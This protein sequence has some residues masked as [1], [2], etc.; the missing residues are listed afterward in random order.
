MPSVARRSPASAS[1]VERVQAADRW[2]AP[3]GTGR[4]GARSRSRPA[5]GR[6]RAP[7]AGPRRRP[8]PARRSAARSGRVSS[9]CRPASRSASVSARFTRT[10]RVPPRLGGG[11]VEVAP[12][13]GRDQPPVAVADQVRGVVAVHARPVGSAE[14][15]VRP[16]GQRVRARVQRPHAGV[17]GVEEARPG[18]GGGQQ[19]V[20]AVADRVALPGGDEAQVAQARARRSRR[21]ARRRCPIRPGPRA[22]PAQKASSRVSTRSSRSTRPR[23]RQP[24]ASWV[25]TVRCAPVRVSASRSG[26]GGAADPSAGCGGWWSPRRRPPRD[27]CGRTTRRTTP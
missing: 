19:Q 9:T 24:S 25:S 23:A 3:G 21:S 8:R 17:R 22:G 20:V 13:R 26:A 14:E 27:R 12:G 7:G 16:V 11:Q 6:R 5:T 18:V 15:E 1:S 2:P 10:A 4:T